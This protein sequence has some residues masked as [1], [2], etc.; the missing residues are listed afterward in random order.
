MENPQLKMAQ[1]YLEN[2]AYQDAEQC[3]VNIL[4]EEPTNLE[5]ILGKGVSKAAQATFQDPCFSALNAAFSIAQ[6]LASNDD[7]SKRVVYQK[8]LS[9]FIA[10]SLK[11]DKIRDTCRSIR[12]DAMFES[13]GNLGKSLGF[14]I[15]GALLLGKDHEKINSKN[16]DGVYTTFVSALAKCG[17]KLLSEL[18]TNFLMSDEELKCLYVETR[19]VMTFYY[20]AVLTCDRALVPADIFADSKLHAERNLQSFN[21]MTAASRRSQPSPKSQQNH[22]VQK[23]L[24]SESFLYRFLPTENHT[25][26]LYLAGDLKTILQSA[27]QEVTRRG[28]LLGDP[29]DASGRSCITAVFYSGFMNQMLCHILFEVTKVDDT[30]CTLQITG[31]AKET[32]IK[33]HT[34]Q[35]AVSEISTKLKAIFSN[36]T[37]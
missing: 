14:G 13:L 32:L 35:K 23:L 3:Y 12:K 6:D 26:E 16:F 17:D 11:F 15:G 34:A 8:I 30:R 25:E 37:T 21:D 33:Q 19:R 29:Q 1:R 36:P 22:S 2:E 9:A 27:I 5:A 20:E 4:R 31:T 18:D 24:D 7:Q 28:R 10:T